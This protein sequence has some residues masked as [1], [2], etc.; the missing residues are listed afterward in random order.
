TSSDP[1]AVLPPDTT[2]DPNVNGG[3]AFVNVTLNTEGTQS[4]TAT[5][6]AD[7]SITGSQTDIVVGPGSQSASTTT[8]LTSAPNPSVFGQDVTFTA[9]VAPVAP[10]AGTP[11]GTANLFDGATLLGTAPLSNGVATF[12]TSALAV[13]S[14]DV[15]AVYSGDTNFTAST[16]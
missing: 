11:T 4:I 15:T 16:S 13:G 1:A 7:P 10:V 2:F 14:H 6:T 12:T 5:D 3:V 9:T 8:S